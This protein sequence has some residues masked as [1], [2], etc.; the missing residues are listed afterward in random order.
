MHRPVPI[1]RHHQDQHDGVHRADGSGEAVRHDGLRHRPQAVSSRR[2]CRALW[3]GLPEAELQ[4][5][6]RQLLLFRR[7]QD[8]RENI[9]LILV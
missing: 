7:G 6:V 5:H 4:R 9:Q 1:L 2:H 8:H 3:R